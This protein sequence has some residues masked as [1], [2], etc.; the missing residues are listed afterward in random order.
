MNE[1]LSDWHLE[2]LFV[3][4]CTFLIIGIFHPLVIKGYYYFGMKCRWWFAVGAVV[5]CAASVLLDGFILSTLC[6]VTG[7]SSLWSIREINDQ[8][9]RVRKGWFPEGPAQRKQKDLL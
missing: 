6:G 2:G 4:L 9:E 7:F 1:I 3:G 8:R 5:F